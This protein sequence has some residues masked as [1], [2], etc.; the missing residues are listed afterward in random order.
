M[1]RK[2]T[3]IIFSIIISVMGYF[4]YRQYAEIQDLEMVLD[5]CSDRYYELILKK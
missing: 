2:I 4:L 5:Q 3:Y 1:K